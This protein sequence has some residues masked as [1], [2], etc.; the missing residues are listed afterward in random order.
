MSNFYDDNDMVENNSA[1]VLD[2]SCTKA[3]IVE[4]VKQ[5]GEITS[6]DDLPSLSWE[7]IQSSPPLDDYALDILREVDRTWED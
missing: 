4:K 6:Y 2:G 3:D 1:D 5:A 7:Q